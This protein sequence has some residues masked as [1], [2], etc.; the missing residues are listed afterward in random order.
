[1]RIRIIGCTHA[2]TAAAIN[3]AKENTNAEIVVY[4]RNDNVSFLSC[5]IALYVGGFIQDV[6]GL[7]Y[8]SP[9]ALSEMGIQTKMK[10]DVLKV[11]VENKKLR[12]KDLETDEITDDSF[13]KLIIT[14]GSW[15]IQPP[16]KNVELENILLSK[17]FDHANKIIEKS[18]SAKNVVVVGAGYIGV[19]LAEAFERLGKKVTLVDAI[20]RI[21]NKYLD[22]EFTDIAE[23]EFRKNGVNLALGEL[24]E[25][26][27]GQAGKVTKVHTNKGSYEADLVVMC[28]GFRP[29]TTLVSDQI[30][31]L[32]N[33]AIKVNEYM[34]TSHPD[35][36][37]AGDS[38]AIY[39]NPTEEYRYIPLATN[40]IRMGTLAGKNLVENQLKYQGT[41]GTS[42]IK[43]Y[44]ANFSST[45]L[46]E[47][48]IEGT[49]IDYET[50]TVQDHNKPAFMPDHEMVTLKLL[51]RKE[52]KVLLGAQIYSKADMTQY[53]N[54]LS[55]ALQNKMTLQ[56]LAVVDFFFQPHYNKPWSIINLA[57][58]KGL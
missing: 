49:D 5:G 45:G 8:S 22:P 47:A 42:G 20:D 25:S 6:D 50:V 4:E 41:Q 3:A 54:T 56:E 1:M 19:E 26:F 58:Q 14:T 23:D 33:G 46:T 31:T 32:D 38:C 51:Y 37:A 2:G 40:A 48:S 24:V 18:Q 11:D 43:I 16:I 12:V 27:E 10:H 13:D 52:D 15:P 57:A 34:Q 9:E 39:Y 29:N 21:M 35:V 53:V 7:F 17:N 30:E 28:I 36:Y 55:V 44:E